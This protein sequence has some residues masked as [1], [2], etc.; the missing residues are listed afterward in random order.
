[1][2]KIALYTN[3]GSMTD[4]K[5]YQSINIFVNPLFNKA[6]FCQILMYAFKLVTRKVRSLCKKNPRKDQ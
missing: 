6:K 1:M 4:K 5:M 3:N 2:K